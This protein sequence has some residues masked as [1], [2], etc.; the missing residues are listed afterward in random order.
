MR[1]G[2]LVLTSL[3]GGYSCVASGAVSTHVALLEAKLTAGA[4][5]SHTP[6]RPPIK[7]CNRAKGYC[8]QSDT[9]IWWSY[10]TGLKMNHVK[11]SSHALWTLMVKIQGLIVRPASKIRCLFKK[12]VSEKYTIVLNNKC[13]L[14]LHR[15]RNCNKYTDMWNA[16]KSYYL[17]LYLYDYRTRGVMLIRHVCMKAEFKTINDLLVPRTRDPLGLYDMQLILVL[18]FPL[19]PWVQRRE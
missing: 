14:W 12:A 3:S 11:C 9:V 17:Y 1:V 10:D 7:P 15:P 6:P 8:L 13:C 16:L 2:L 5:Q 4:L 19:D 18:C